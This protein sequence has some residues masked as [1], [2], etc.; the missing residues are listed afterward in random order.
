MEEEV[1]SLSAFQVQG[2]GPILNVDLLAA[3]QAEALDKALPTFQTLLGLFPV[4]IFWWQLRL[5]L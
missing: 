4:W 5:E 2:V 1:E 3:H